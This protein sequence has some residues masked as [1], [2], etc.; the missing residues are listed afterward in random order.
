VRDNGIHIAIAALLAVLAGPAVQAA[1]VRLHLSDA[2]GAP[3]GEAVAALE[4]A[5]AAPVPQRPGVSTMAQENQEFTP[6]VL[7][8]GRGERVSFPNRDDTQHHVYSFSPAKIFELPM[9]KG[10]TPAPI[11][12]DQAGVVTLG[13][14]IHDHMR[15]FIFVAATPYFAKT[16][17][18]GEVRL[19]VPAG[20][21][22]L[23]LWHP[24]AIEAPPR[25]PLVV[26]ADDQTL[27]RRIPVKPPPEPP[28]KGLKAWVAK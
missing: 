12:F 8:V 7:A 26:T 17:A 24:R 18:A 20:D 21:Y 28:V 14:N 19:E 22:Q 15:G 23:V 2:D 27:A 4:P 16:D 1:E 9:Y 11:E 13:C 25:E 5:G 6:G 3:L 10:E